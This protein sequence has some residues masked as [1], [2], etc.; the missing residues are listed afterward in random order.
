MGVSLPP[1]HHPHSLQLFGVAPQQHQP[2]GHLH[3]QRRALL[4]RSPNL[5]LNGDVPRCP[6]AV[7]PRQ[8]V[9]LHLWLLGGL[10]HVPGDR[11]RRAGARLADLL[12]QEAAGSVVHHHAG[13][14]E[15]VVTSLQI[16]KHFGHFSENS[17]GSH[18][19]EET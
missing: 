14:E 6:A 11:H 7:P 16:S 13:Q 5:R 12:Q 19:G 18:S 3:D 4:R 8:S 15:E 10:R 17:C 1:Q 9:P 2:P